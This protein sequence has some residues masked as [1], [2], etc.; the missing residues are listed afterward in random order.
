MRVAADVGRQDETLE[1][2]L[3]HE[4]RQHHELAEEVKVHLA[5]AR[6]P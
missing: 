6:R 5:E 3:D 1:Q 2:G 4:R